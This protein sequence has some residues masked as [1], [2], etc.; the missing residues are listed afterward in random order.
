M[1]NTSEISD[2]STL[3]GVYWTPPYRIVIP[4]F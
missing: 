4:A 1:R 2:P 3:I